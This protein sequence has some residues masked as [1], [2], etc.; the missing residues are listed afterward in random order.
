MKTWRPV[1]TETL[2][3]DGRMTELHLDGQR[4]LLARVQGQY[5]AVQAFCAHMGGN[6]EKGNLEGYVVSCP[7]NTSRFD[8]R[9]G[10]VVVWLGRFPGLVRSMAGKIQHPKSLRTFSPR[11]H[12]GQVWVQFEPELAPVP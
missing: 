9:D 2:L 8:L 1:G 3:E 12:D 6:L 11:L 4:I 10:S 5:F 7:R